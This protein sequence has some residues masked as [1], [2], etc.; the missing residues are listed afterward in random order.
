[1]KYEITEKQLAFLSNF[2]ERKGFLESETKLELMDHLICDFE[3]NGNGNLSE[4]L[5]EKLNFIRLYSFKNANKKD[6]YYRRVYFKETVKEFQNFFLDKKKIPITILS[7][8]VIY[9]ISF[10]LTKDIII[11]S[12]LTSLLSCMI[13]GFFINW[14]KT[15]KALRKLEE[16]RSF[17]LDTSI[18][19]F[20]FVFP[21]ALNY[22]IINKIIFSVTWF[23][24]F[25][26]SLSSIFQMK[27]KKKHLLEKY[28]HLLS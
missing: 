20:I 8:L 15:N 17:G 21:N 1:M 27:K 22:L 24:F 25:F 13:Y 5:S 9:L 16:I 4:F 11:I 7:A 10:H 18:P 14:F 3:E 23:V 26:Y 6:K 12:F 28:K 2:L 19:F